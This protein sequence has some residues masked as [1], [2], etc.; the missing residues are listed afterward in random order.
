[1]QQS[2]ALFYNPYLR[3]WQGWWSMWF[4]LWTTPLPMDRFHVHT[5]DIHRASLD[6][7]NVGDSARLSHCVELQDV[8]AFAGLT[9]DV[10]PVH[11]DEAYARETIFRERIAHGMYTGSFFGTIFGTALPGPGAIYVRQSLS[12]RAPVKLGDEIKVT[13]ELVELMPE[14]RAR[15]ECRA[16]VGNRTVLTGEAVLLLPERSSAARPQ[17]KVV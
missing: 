1:M 16:L 14:R 3:L 17:L 7:F 13:V 11:L 8:E 12:F 15:F 5:I 6:D 2:L 10:N 4:G 9:G